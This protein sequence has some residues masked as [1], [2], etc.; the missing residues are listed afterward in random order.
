VA[1]PKTPLG[2][3]AQVELL[4]QRGLVV[5]G[6]DD[7]LGLCS[8]MCAFFRACCGWFLA[9][10]RVFGLVGTVVACRCPA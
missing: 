10:L 3:V 4:M 6:T 8:R 9:G 2:I 5:C 1:D 7:K